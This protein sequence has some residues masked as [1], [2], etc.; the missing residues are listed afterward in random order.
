MNKFKHLALSL[1]LSLGIFV[2]TA[3]LLNT[4]FVGAS[5]SSDLICGGVNTESGGTAECNGDAAG[6]Q[7]SSLLKTGITIFQ[8]I[9]GIIALFVL[10]VGGLGYVTSGGDTSKTKTA[11]DR[12][13]YAVIGLVVVGLSQVI[14]QFT[15]NRVN[16]SSTTPAVVAPEATPVL[17]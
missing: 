11:K 2:P 17:P 5:A 13:L 16:E 3:T 7:V 6:E 12:I 1:V 9:I 4:S 8:A 10:M 15:L 14:V